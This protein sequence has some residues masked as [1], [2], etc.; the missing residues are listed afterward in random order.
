M[1]RSSVIALHDC[2]HRSAIGGKISGPHDASEFGSAGLPRMLS[3]DGRQCFLRTTQPESR[4]IWPGEGGFLRFVSRGWR[5]WSAQQ[6]VC[7]IGAATP[8]H[9]GREDCVMGALNTPASP[10]RC[11]YLSLPMRSMERSISGLGKQKVRLAR[12]RNWVTTGPFR[13]ARYRISRSRRVRSACGWKFIPRERVFRRAW[14][15]IPGFSASF[16]GG[17]PPNSHSMRERC[18]HEVRT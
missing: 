17:N 6:R 15:G 9:P 5:F 7:S 13:V 8:W 4:S 3:R 16:P 18:M 14:D 12:P 10:S 1:N 2:V 11:R